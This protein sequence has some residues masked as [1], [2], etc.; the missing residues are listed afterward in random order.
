MDELERNELKFQTFEELTEDVRQKISRCLDANNEFLFCYEPTGTA[1]E[2]D[3]ARDLI[4]RF[5][6]PEGK[7]LKI[8]MPGPSGN[9]WTDYVSSYR[10]KLNSILVK[11]AK[12][13]VPAKEI[14]LI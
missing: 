10:V 12:E 4:E 13:D 2:I 11:A 14:V 5:R 9:A 8:E 7:I 3:T 1:R 6:I